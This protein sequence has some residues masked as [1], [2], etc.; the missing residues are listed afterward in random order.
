MVFPTTLR[1]RT[2]LEMLLEKEDNITTWK[3]WDEQ[4]PWSVY[5]SEYRFLS[6]SCGKEK[7]DMFCAPVSDLVLDCSSVSK[8]DT[9]NSEDDYNIIISV[10]HLRD[11][12][13]TKFVCRFCRKKFTV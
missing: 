5:T 13:T 2:Q 12:L 8:Y 7:K 3:Q 6:D 11:I 1:K 4:N 10:S 9:N